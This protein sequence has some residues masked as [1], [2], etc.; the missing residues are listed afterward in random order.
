MTDRTDHPRRSPAIEHLHRE[1]EKDMQ[2]FYSAFKH[3]TPE[4]TDTLPPPDMY[5][6][7]VLD[8]RERYIATGDGYTPETVCRLLA[9][10]DERIRVL[11]ETLA[12]AQIIIGHPDD[13]MSQHIEAVLR[14]ARNG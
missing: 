14:E 9:E 4:R 12:M 5:D 13:A 8:E 2:S 10:R 1:V 7:V 11:T 6:G 3:L